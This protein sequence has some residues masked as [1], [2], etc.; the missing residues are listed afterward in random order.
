MIWPSTTL[1]A[2]IHIHAARLAVWDKF[3]RLRE[4]PQWRSDVQVI[5]WQNGD[6]WQEG[7]HF[8]MQQGDQ[9]RAYL[10]RMVSHGN[11][12]VWE[13]EG[14][15]LSPVYSL[16]LSDQ[17]GGCKVSLRC[18]YHGFGV[19]GALLQRARQQQ[20]LRELLEALKRLIERKESR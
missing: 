16:Q 10:I 20:Q 7:A 1:N 18:T 4:W 5:T 17:L 14:G 3:T 12:T 15:A 8:S 13:E 9:R 6:R 19:L 2:E 11:V